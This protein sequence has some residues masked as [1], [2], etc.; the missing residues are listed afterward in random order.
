MKKRMTPF[1][2]NPRLV[3]RLDEHAAH[4]G[5]TRTKLVETILQAFC[6]GRLREVPRGGPNPFPEEEIVA[7]ESSDFPVLI[8]PSTRDRVGPPGWKL[9]ETGGIGIYNPP[10]ENPCGEIKLDTSAGEEAP[11]EVAS[12]EQED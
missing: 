6:E 3:D 11:V 2:L 5:W 12:E 8:G 4:E 9:G 7:G 1:R 10:R